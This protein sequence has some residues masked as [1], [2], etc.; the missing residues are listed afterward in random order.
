MVSRPSEIKIPNLFYCN[1]FKNKLFFSYSLREGIIPHVVES[2]NNLL[3]NK[4]YFMISNPFMSVST[5][6]GCSAYTFL[7]MPYH[8][9]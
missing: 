6:I 8:R 2:E 4:S 7:P 1:T 9:S 5:E 3:W